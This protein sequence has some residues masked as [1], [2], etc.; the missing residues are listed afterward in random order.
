[1][2]AEKL[3]LIGKIAKL[4]GFEGDALIYF[5]ETYLKKISKAE[6]VFLTIDGLPVPFFI[7][8][9]DLRSDSTA[10][11]RLTDIDSAED[12]EKLLGCEFAIIET[13]KGRKSSNLSQ[14]NISG[15]SVID[16]NA[17]EIGKAASVLNFNDNMVLQVIKG[18]KEILVPVAEEIIINVDDS[19]KIISVC[20]PEGLLELNP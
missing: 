10:I 17:G 4:H 6:W 11:I 16:E 1:M 2:I 19:K 8:K 13:G 7:S 9:L 12:M 15:Y 14:A 20:L 18:N 5:D 3:R